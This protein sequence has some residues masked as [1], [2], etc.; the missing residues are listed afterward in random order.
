MFITGK[1]TISGGGKNK[2]NRLSK[3][4]STR[5]RNSRRQGK[6]PSSLR[7]NSG[8]SKTHVD[9]VGVG[10]EAVVVVV[11]VAAEQ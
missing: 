9:V 5:K 10:V 1:K 6:C 11:V 3:Q 8:S 4:T 2:I 7:R